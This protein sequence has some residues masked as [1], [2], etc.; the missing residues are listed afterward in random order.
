MARKPSAKPWRHQASG[1]W[2]ATVRG[3]RVYL[4]R[5]YRAACR[6]LRELRARA[7][8]EE[9]LGRDWLQAT[10]AELADDYLE[11]VQ[12]RREPGTYVS[13]RYRLLRALKV[14]G[15]EVRVG[16]L[17]KKHLAQI[18]RAL[19]RG[20]L[21]SGLQPPS[22]TQLVGLRPP[23]RVR[24]PLAHLRS[25]PCFGYAS[26]GPS[27]TAG[28]RSTLTTSRFSHNGWYMN[29][30]KAI[31]TNRGCGPFAQRLLARASSHRRPISR[32]DER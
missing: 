31:P 28:Q 3:K 11:D 5:D 21:A 27:A 18:E 24:G 23:G 20:S 29:R 16:E 17:R 30:G 25:G 12:A 7:E 1:L 9:T 26:A 14:I 6:Q 2:C 10:F 4:G 8:R 22:A 13:A 19:V 32:N 15:R